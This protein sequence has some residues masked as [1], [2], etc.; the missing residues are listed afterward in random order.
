LINTLYYFDSNKKLDILDY[1]Y[2]ELRLCVIEKRCC[3]YAPHLQLLIEQCIGTEVH[4]YPL[5]THRSL[6]MSVPLTADERQASTRSKRRTQEEAPGVE[7]VVRNSRNVELKE[8][9]KSK[10]KKVFCQGID[11]KDQN[12]KL[13]REN[14]IIRTQNKEIMRKLGIP[15][16]SGS[17]GQLTTSTA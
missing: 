14:K 1:M 10:L 17:E 16:A 12:Y 5:T 13:H 6:T 9:W 3:I 2:N 7:E 8:S 4:N 15:V 11:I